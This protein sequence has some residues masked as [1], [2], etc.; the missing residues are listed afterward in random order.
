M[1]SAHL[2]TLTYCVG[3]IK[4]RKHKF[5]EIDNSSL[6]S[7]FVVLT[8]LES[9]LSQTYLSPFVVQINLGQ[10]EFSLLH[11]NSLQAPSV[12]QTEVKNTQGYSYT[13][14]YD[15]SKFR[16]HGYEILILA[17]SCVSPWY[18]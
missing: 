4:S 6:Q 17:L 12:G 2:F 3:K 7:S 16:P 10:Q 11:T 5:S 15:R 18:I 13:F 9:T 1:G 14:P 8:E